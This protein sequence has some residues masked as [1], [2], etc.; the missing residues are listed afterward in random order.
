MYINKKTLINIFFHNAINS[1]LDNS[2][3]LKG[4]K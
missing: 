3:S 2:K 1:L 4:F